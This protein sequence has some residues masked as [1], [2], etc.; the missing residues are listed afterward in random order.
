[1]LVQESLIGPILIRFLRRV[2]TSAYFL[3]LMSDLSLCRV[4]ITGSV[5]TLRPDHATCTLAPAQN[6]APALYPTPLPALP[7]PLTLTL[8]SHPMPSPRPCTPEVLAVTVNFNF[9]LIIVQGAGGK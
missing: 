2:S 1:M 9:S 8:P 7:C 3:I 4:P 5:Q 6:P